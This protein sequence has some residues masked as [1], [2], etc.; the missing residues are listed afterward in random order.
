M[1]ESSITVK[2]QSSGVEARTYKKTALLSTGSEGDSYAQAVVPL[3]GSVGSWL[4]LYAQKYN[5]YNPTDATIYG[6]KMTLPGSMTAKYYNGAS[7]S[8]ATQL[9]VLRRRPL[10]SDIYAPGSGTSNY[11]EGTTQSTTD[12]AV[13]DQLR[14]FLAEGLLDTLRLTGSVQFKAKLSL[15]TSNA[16]G[17]A[18]L[19]SVTFKLRK[20][21]ATDT[22]TDIGS[23]TVTLGLTS[24]ATTYVDYSVVAD[25]QLV[26]PVVVD[27]DEVLLLEVSTVGK[28]SSESYTTTHKV[29][30]SLGTS[31]TFVDLMV[32]D[33]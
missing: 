28:N 19:T 16:S 21:T 27:T 14:F 29:S 5:A 25:I 32:E 31:E 13:I 11:F 10:P 18:T 33:L 20:L 24:T 2:D 3:R 1:V 23:K 7:S 12:E 9:Y 6:E 30:F 26:T 17:T 4:T 22:Y 8:T 15:K